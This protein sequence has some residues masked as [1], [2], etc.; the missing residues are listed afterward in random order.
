MNKITKAAIAGSIGVALLLGGAGT[1]AT[2]N[3]SAP[4]S[5]GTIVAGN[6]SVGA[7]ATATWTV[8]HLT[9]GSTTAYDAAVTTTLATYKASPGDKLTYTTTMPVTV[10]GTLL[11]VKSSLTPGSV[12]ATSSGP[13]LPADAAMVTALTGNVVTTLSLPIAGAITGSAPTYTITPGATPLSTTAT[14]TATLTFPLNATSGSENGY[15]AGSV[16]LSAM[17]VTLTQTN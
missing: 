6:L 7:P 14:V 13:T 1:L 17:A 10:S 8:Q 4:I 9:I 12:T 16:N 3:A 5:G 2:W 11:Q 15:M